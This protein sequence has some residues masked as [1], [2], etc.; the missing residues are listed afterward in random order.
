MDRDPNEDGYND[1]CGA[2]DSGSENANHGNGSNDDNGSCNLPKIV[3]IAK[4]GGGFLDGGRN[5]DH[6]KRYVKNNPVNWIDS[7][8]LNLD[9]DI[10][11]CG[12]EWVG[13]PWKEDTDETRPQEGTIWLNTIIWP[14]APSIKTR[15]NPLSYFSIIKKIRYDIEWFERKVEVW[16][17]RMWVCRDKCKNETYRGWASS[18]CLGYGWEKISDSEKNKKRYKP[19]YDISFG[20]FWYE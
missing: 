7:A 8:G 19:D 11:D 5:D 9:S 20:P 17:A 12:H 4:K 2:G 3:V 15:H 10:P 1:C 13:K 14:P 18:D 16:Q 6:D